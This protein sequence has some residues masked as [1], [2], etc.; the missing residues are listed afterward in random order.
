LIFQGNYTAGGKGNQER[1]F[2]CIEKNGPPG[3]G[4]GELGMSKHPLA[5]EH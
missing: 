2:V 3:P 4:G 1:F 5:G